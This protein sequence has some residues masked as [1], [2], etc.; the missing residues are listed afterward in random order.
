MIGPVL[1][2]RMRG[3]DLVPRCC[4]IIVATVYGY[5]CNRR[6]CL[7][8]LPGRCSY[9]VSLLG[10]AAYC[11]FSLHVVNRVWAGRRRSSVSRPAF[12]S[13][14]PPFW[15]SANCDALAR[16]AHRKIEKFL[17]RLFRS[18]FCGLDGQDFVVDWQ[19]CRR[20]IQCNVREWR[21]E[22]RRLA[23]VLNPHV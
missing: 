7:Y 18:N 23:V 8:R 15:F 17:R 4:E 9:E 20:N 11:H 13:T 14:C 12:P 1:S 16:L 22:R 19:Q 2:V 21:L 5:R 6:P 3:W 10:V